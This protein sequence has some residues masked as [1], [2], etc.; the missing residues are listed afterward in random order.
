[1]K[2]DII[3]YFISSVNRASGDAY[4]CYINIGPIGENFDK[5]YCKCIAFNMNVNTLVAGHPQT[6]TLVVSDLAENGY[7]TFASGTNSLLNNEMPIAWLNCDNT[8]SVM[9]SGEGAHFIVSNLRQQRRI[10]FRVC[11][12]LLNF[13]DGT[14]FNGTEWN[15]VLLLEPIIE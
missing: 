3:T 9:A 8:G 10:R 12:D 14:Y 7:R 13:E 11:D 15:C 4:D 5:Y 1:M 2:K 6:Y